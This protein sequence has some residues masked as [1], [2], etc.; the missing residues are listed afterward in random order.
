VSAGP[1]P[2][3]VVSFDAGGTLI[4]LAEPVGATYARLARRA[5]FTADIA[6]LEEGFRR[7]TAAAPPLAPPAGFAGDLLAFERGWWRDVVDASLAYALGGAP[8]ARHDAARARFFDDAFA[9]YARPEA[10]RLDPD[11]RPLIAG[12]RA[13]G[14]RLVVISNF[15]RRLHPLLDGFGLGGAIELAVASSE[16]G[17]VKPDPAIFAHALARL[18]GARPS[19]CLHVGDSAREDAAG[20]VAAGWRAAWLDR[21]GDDPPATPP[22]GAERISRL[23]DLATLVARIG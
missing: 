23:G 22:D 2:L 18:P 13:R 11:V 17:A 3:R 8:D 21:T 1:T 12:L 15:D 6:A 14:L 20:A 9:H 7:A 4:A 19:G 10:W 5:G 16:A